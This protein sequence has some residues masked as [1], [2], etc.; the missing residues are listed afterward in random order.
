M[1]IALF[2]NGKPCTYILRSYYY[3]GCK[4]ETAKPFA[5]KCWLRVDRLSSAIIYG[6]TSCFKSIR[7]LN[8]IL[9]G[10]NLVLH[11]FQGKYIMAKDMYLIFENMKIFFP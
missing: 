8:L 2:D 6:V 4:N 11:D 1:P 10:T 3:G 5:V 9:D 7:N